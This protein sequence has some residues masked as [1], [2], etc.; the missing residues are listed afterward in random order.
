MK[1]KERWTSMPQVREKSLTSREE[2]ERADRSSRKS[3]VWAAVRPMLGLPKTISPRGLSMM[4]GSMEPKARKARLAWPKSLAEAR[5]RPTWAKRSIRADSRLPGYIIIS[6][7]FVD[8][9]LNA[10]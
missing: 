8:F 3:R 10:G 4:S 1:S 7:K 2:K 6:K 5:A 9:G